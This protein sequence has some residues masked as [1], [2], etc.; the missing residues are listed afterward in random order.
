MPE[1]P[2]EPIWLTVHRDLK[3]TPRVRA[4]L[5][6]LL[7]ALSEDAELLRGTPKAAQSRA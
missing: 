4:V 1:E 2:S 7:R 3:Q 5:D 6:H